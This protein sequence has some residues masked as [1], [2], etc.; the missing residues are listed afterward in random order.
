MQARIAARFHVRDAFQTGRR[1]NQDRGRLA[2][3]RADHRHVASMVND[4]LFLLERGF[5]LLVH[6]DAAQGGEGEE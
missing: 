3:P 2:E 5:M 1:G 4:T 6:D